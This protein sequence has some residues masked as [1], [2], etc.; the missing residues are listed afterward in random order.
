M[1][2][3]V[4]LCSLVPRKIAKLSCSLNKKVFKSLNLGI[5]KKRNPKVDDAMKKR[6]SY[7]LFCCVSVQVTVLLL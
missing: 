3:S 5:T 4:V 1:P 2:K 7:F 6:E